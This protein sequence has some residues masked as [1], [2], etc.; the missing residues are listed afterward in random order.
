MNRSGANRGS[1]S[2]AETIDVTVVGGG[3]AGLAAAIAAAERLSAAGRRGSVVVFDG[4]ARIGAKILIA[5][6]GRC[7]V[8][9]REV[10]AGDF[11]GSHNIVRN[12][13]A[14]FDGA[15]T[16]RW[17]ASMGVE[18]KCEE[19]GKLFPVTDKARTVVD[20]LLQRCAQLDVAIRLDHR[21]AAVRRAG[22]RFAVLHARGEVSAR[23]VIL[24]SGGRSL[25]RTGSD[26]HGWEIA[27]ALGHSVTPVHPALVPLVLARSMFHRRL[28]G[29]SHAAE[30]STYACG[31]RV[32]R[33][34]GS[35]LWTHFGVSGPVVLDA[36]RH[37]LAARLRGGAVELRCNF[38]PGGDFA[39]ADEWLVGAAAARPRQS[40]GRCLAGRWPER[41]AECLAA[42]ARIDSGT[43]LGQ[44]PRDDRRRLAHVLT[45]LVLPV[46]GDRGWDFAEVTA[47][48]VPL[49]EIDF[50]SM[51]SRRTPGLHLIG[52]MLDCDGRI[53]GF[54]FQWA[55]STGHIAGRA[56]ATRA[57]R[58]PAE[59]PGAHTETGS[60]AP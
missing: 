40:V 29:T 9:N 45:E 12:V 26:G 5:G 20:A 22:E 46:E 55:W 37:W 15:A 18:L 57:L 6:G 36:S 3:A 53:G 59:E 24:A 58:P 8:T 38:L 47:G 25:P 4:A 30:L 42:A 11:N 21:V 34:T 52:E 13:L 56:A 44:L 31:K 19:H 39:Q 32:D 23:A 50:R 35:L 10:V 51:E 7:N 28:S 60:R 33:R 1:V 48:G 43:A 54:N 41:L 49:P 2:S 16:V 17:F 14:A 27:R